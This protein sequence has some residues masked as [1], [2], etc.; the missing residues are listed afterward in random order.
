MTTA[1][2]MYR[3]IP[4][5]TSRRQ[6]RPAQPETA[7]DEIIG[8]WRLLDNALDT[9]C[10]EMQTPRPKAELARPT[11]SLSKAARSALEHRFGANIR[12]I[13]L[14]KQCGGHS[15]EEVIFAYRLARQGIY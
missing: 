13:E 8:E 3:P 10:Q 14:G 5:D 15:R 7:D 4:A 9:L 12:D 1:L 2:S 11:P 6:R